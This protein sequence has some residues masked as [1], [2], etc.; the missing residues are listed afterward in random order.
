[1]VPA[2]LLLLCADNPELVVHQ[3]VPKILLSLF[4]MLFESKASLSQADMNCCSKEAGD[5]KVCRVEYR[6]EAQDSC[7]KFDSGSRLVLLVLGT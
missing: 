6:V 7:P 4:T 2:R 3:M 5:I 1:M